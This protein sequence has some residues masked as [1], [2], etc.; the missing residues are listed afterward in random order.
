VLH[1][2]PVEDV[3]QSRVAAAFRGGEP[4]GRAGAKCRWRS[5]REGGEFWAGERGQF[6]SGAGGAAEAGAVPR[7]RR[8]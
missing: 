7:S 1:S 3:G 8:R 5:R 4:E 6:S 2:A